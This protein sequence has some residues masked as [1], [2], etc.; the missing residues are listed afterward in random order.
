MKKKSL[1][2]LLDQI[3]SVDYACLLNP[4]HYTDGFP[5]KFATGKKA[6][7]WNE[8]IINDHTNY[9]GFL[10]FDL[11][12]EIFDTL[13]SNNKDYQDFPEST[14]FKAQMTLGKDEL[15]NDLDSRDVE[16]P[17]VTFSAIVTKE[18][19]ISQVNSIKNHILNGDV[20]ELNYCISFV[21]E[22]IELNAVDLYKKLNEISP[23]PFSSLLKLKDC[24]LICASPE[25]YINKDIRRFIPFIILQ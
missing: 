7:L 18:E 5:L 23:M 2:R 15:L 21:A 10:A 25:R 24:W 22:N 17:K 14:F 13:V 11:K 12:N 4:N 8:L 3:H 19:Y 6:I 9:F 16:I 20:Y 1:N